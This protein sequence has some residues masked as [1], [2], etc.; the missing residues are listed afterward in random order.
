ML[1]QVNTQQ[2]LQAS[3]LFAIHALLART[4]S[5]AQ[6]NELHQSSIPHQQSKGQ[7]N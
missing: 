3:H 1:T 4:G 2:F 7:G 5:E 6:R